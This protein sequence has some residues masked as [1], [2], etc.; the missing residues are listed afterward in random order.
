MP[1]SAPGSKLGFPLTRTSP[2]VGVMRPAATI[3]SVDL[4]QPEGPTMHANCPSGTVS[5]MRS[6]AVTSP[7]RL[8]KRI[9]TSV[10]S[11]SLM[12][13]PSPRMG[14]RGD[15]RWQRGCR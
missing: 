8:R 5:E 12:R 15:G 7:W 1:R 2:S 4:P 3:N 14:K 9:A 13:G 10:I 11:I 6:R